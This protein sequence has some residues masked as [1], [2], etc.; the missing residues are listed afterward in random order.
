MTI[1]LSIIALCHSLSDDSYSRPIHS[2]K[3]VE[4]L[5]VSNSPL[6][7]LDDICGP[8]PGQRIGYYMIAV[9]GAD[10]A[11]RFNYAIIGFHWEPRR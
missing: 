11:G 5:F 4:Y 7:L 8:Y 1:N 9:F 10:L 3:A 6:G 2:L